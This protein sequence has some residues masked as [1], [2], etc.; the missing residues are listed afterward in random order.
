MPSKQWLRVCHLAECEGIVCQA[1]ATMIPL[2]RGFFRT[3]VESGPSLA[4]HACKSHLSHTPTSFPMVGS[5]RESW[6][7]IQIK[8]D[9]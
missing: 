8:S 3:Y 6:Q 2:D 1:V 9:G 4:A 7:Q 5:P